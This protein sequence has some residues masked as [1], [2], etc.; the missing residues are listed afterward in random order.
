MQISAFEVFYQTDGQA[1][2]VREAVAANG[3]NGASYMEA[4]LSTVTCTL[5]RGIPSSILAFTPHSGYAVE[6]TARRSAMNS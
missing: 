6:A 4:S 5:S 1:R 2:A 3:L